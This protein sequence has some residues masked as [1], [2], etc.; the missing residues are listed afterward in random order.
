MDYATFQVYD[1]RHQ[2]KDLE[3]SYNYQRAVS[4]E[5]TE[6]FVYYAKDK[7][8]VYFNGLPIQGA[9]PDTYEVLERGIFAKDDSQIFFRS[10]YEPYAPN[11]PLQGVDVETFEVLSWEY[12]KDKQNVY[13]V[14]DCGGGSG[15]EA[16]IERVKNA[17]PTTFVVPPSALFQQQDVVAYDKNAL[18]TRG[19][20]RVV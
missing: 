9:N 7:N 19:G 2:I 15:R 6:I 16:C 10:W 14:F 8:H 12:A 1:T 4:F 20:F 13:E 5:G 18:Y 11:I 3:H 17:D